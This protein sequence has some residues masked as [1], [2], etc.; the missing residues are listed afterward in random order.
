MVGLGLVGFVDDF[1]KTRNQRSLGLG[2]WAKIAGQVIVAAGFAVL[3]LNFP[4]AERP[5]AGID[6]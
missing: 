4:D 3:A 2:G 6:R 1:L 5:D